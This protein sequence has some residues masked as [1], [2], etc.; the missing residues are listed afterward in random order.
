[1]AQ[2]GFEELY[3]TYDVRKGKADARRAYEKLAPSS[4]QHADMM[5]AALTWKEAGGSIERMH[6]A[7]WIREERYDEDP[8][9]ERKP[10]DKKDR[11]AKAEPAAP[12]RNGKMMKIVDITTRG[13]PFG[14]FYVTIHLEGDN[15]EAIERELQILASD[16]PGTDA[17]LYSAMRKA[18]HASAPDFIGKR[19]SISMSSTGVVEIHPIDETKAWDS[20][21]EDAAEE[22]IIEPFKER[23]ETLTII[24]ATVESDPEEDGG[25]AV[26]WL[27]LVFRRHEDGNEDMGESFV[28]E[29]S[30][31]KR[32]EDGQEDLQK[33]LRLV[34]IPATDEPEELVGTTFVRSLRSKFGK[35]EY[36]L[37]PANDNRSDSILTDDF[38]PAP[39]EPRLPAGVSF[40]NV[41]AKAP[42]LGWAAKI[43]TAHDDDDEEDAA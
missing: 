23:R 3:R 25:D 18:Y 32:Q 30:N 24:S 8:R 21:S 6:L 10:R 28:V 12:T 14:E 37:V 36:E 22:P 40:A 42:R 20:E 15:G 11:P 31:P 17:D 34:G 43:G 5:A 13:N 39:R 1:M 38:V 27:D 29:S 19:A 2:G 9:G 41:V 4:E 33:F 35:Y 16:G 7:R 26:K